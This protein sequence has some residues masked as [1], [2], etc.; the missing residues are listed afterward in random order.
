VPSQTAASMQMILW[1]S[2]GAIVGGGIVGA[3][4]ALAK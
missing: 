4:M 3:L 2:I 1:L